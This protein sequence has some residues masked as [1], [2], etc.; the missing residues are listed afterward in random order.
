MDRK[1]E[2]AM[3]LNIPNMY[4]DYY[5]TPVSISVSIRFYTIRVRPLDTNRSF[6]C[7]S[8]SLPV[9]SFNYTSTPCRHREPNGTPNAIA[10][11]RIV[12][13]EQWVI[14]RERNRNMEFTVYSVLASPCF[15]CCPWPR[16][17]VLR[18]CAR[19]H[20]AFVCR[21]HLEQGQSVGQQ[22]GAR[23]S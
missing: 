2:T 16:Q 14:K 12:V 21:L 3:R 19:Q 5:L 18:L 23:G 22:R 17:F 20:R 7:T 10:T 8:M 1:M 4:V 6:H 15:Y 11:P 13:T 9:S